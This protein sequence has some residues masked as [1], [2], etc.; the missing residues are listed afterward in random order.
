MR[1]HLAMVLLLLPA[2]AG[3]ADPAS[4]GALASPNVR[5]HVLERDDLSF[6]RNEVS[7][8]PAV[9]QAN[10]RFTTHVGTGLGYTYHLNDNFGLQI[11]GLYN[12]IAESSSFSSELLTKVREQP[13]AASSLLLKWGVIAGVELSP[14]YGKFALLQN[15]V[16]HIAFGVSAGVGVGDTRIQ[17]RPGAR[18]CDNGSCQDVPAA[19]GETGLKM[20]G[21]VGAGFRVQI[22]DSLLLRLEVHDLVY[23]GSVDRINGC[24]QADLAALNGRAQLGQ[25]FDGVP[26]SSGCQVSRFSGT[27]NGV[28]RALNVQPA[29]D[30][31][32]NQTS[33][34]LNNIGV[35][36]GLGD[37]F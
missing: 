27:A 19:F 23:S 2:G 18:S 35:Y 4:E 17:L 5:P 22:G 34:V 25:G 31:V 15:T 30:L 24:N 9:F 14:L 29:L 13:D 6:Q 28:N 37:V 16:A 1:L 26:V 33:D 8:F 20:L 36:A 7:L 32:R 21:A 3:W 12:W 10:A 11:S